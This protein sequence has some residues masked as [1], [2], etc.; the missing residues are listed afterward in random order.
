MSCAS[1]NS[2]VGRTQRCCR[3]NVAIAPWL[4][5]FHL[6]CDEGT[7]YDIFFCSCG[8][9]NRVAYECAFKL[10]ETSFCPAST[11]VVCQLQLG[12]REKGHNGAAAA[13]W[14]LRPGCHYST[15][16][17]IRGLFMTFSFVLV[18]LLIELRTS[19]LSSCGRL[20]QPPNAPD[21]YARCTP[22][23]WRWQPTIIL[24]IA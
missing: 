10:W 16:R 15:C 2:V 4:S 23:S 3:G 5:L 21:L 6:S 1:F 22:L 20:V 18:V 8:I 9:I 11:C 7:F 13:T 19:V 24:G 14:R 17:A 12:C